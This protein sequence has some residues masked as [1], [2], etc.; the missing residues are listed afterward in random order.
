MYT[1]VPRSGVKLS[2]GEQEI[3]LTAAQLPR[4]TTY[5]A[6]RSGVEDEE[7][8]G[9]EAQDKVPEIVIM[10]TRDSSKD[11]GGTGT[12]RTSGTG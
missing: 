1:A 12:R 3:Q 9:S 7:G 4:D 8:Y 6:S 10:H 2:K 5:T 11:S